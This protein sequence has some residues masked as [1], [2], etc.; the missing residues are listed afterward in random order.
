[1]DNNLILKATIQ[2]FCEC[3]IQSF[4]IDCVKILKHYGY[5]IFTYNELKGKNTELYE[6]CLA[7]SEDAFREGATMIVAYNDEKPT[8]RIRFSLMHELGHH[9]LKHNGNSNNNE[10]EANAF[11]SFILAPRMAIHYAKCKNAND[12]SHI[13]EMSH[14]AAKNAFDDYLRWHRRIVTYKMSQ[15][16]KAMYSHFYNAEHEC[17]VWSIKRCDFCGKIL[18]NSIDGRCRCCTLP[19]PDKS[20]EYEDF[21]WNNNV[22]RLHSAHLKWLYDF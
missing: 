21:L 19:S 7:Y 9:I 18:Y 5:R 14:E 17:F 12:V 20:Y 2:V 15:Y 3:K 22:E 13:F 6:M 8:G 10:K 16:D 1:M 11:A 4:P